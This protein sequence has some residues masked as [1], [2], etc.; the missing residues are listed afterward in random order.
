LV[1]DRSSLGT[2]NPQNPVIILASTVKVRPISHQ[3]RFLLDGQ[4]RHVTIPHD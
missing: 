2:G 4:S 1:I 3:V